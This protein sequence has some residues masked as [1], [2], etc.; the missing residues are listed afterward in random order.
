MSKVKEIN[1]E[2]GF[3]TVDVAMNRLTNELTTAKMS[4]YK[5][6]VIIHGYG[7]SGEGG[8][9]KAAVKTHL[10]KP[11][12]RGIVKSTVSGEE[13]YSKKKEFINSCPGIKSFERHID[14]NQGL[15]VLLFR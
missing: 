2:R 15:T 12:F 6:A 4:G 11:T 8:G 10:T 9:I 7:S 1:L 3:P 14:G 13:W 5:A